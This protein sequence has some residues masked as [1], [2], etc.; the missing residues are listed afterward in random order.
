MIYLGGNDLN[1]N[2][3]PKEIIFKIKKFIEKIIT[4]YPNANIGYISIKPSIERKNK[5]LD[6]KEI[7]K[8][9]KLLSKAYL[10]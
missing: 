5:L 4:K 8:G 3:S 1:L 10:I 7:N 9:I 6:I 2:L